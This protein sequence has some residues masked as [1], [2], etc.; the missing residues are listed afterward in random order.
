MI[1]NPYLLLSVINTALRDE[2]SSLRDYCLS[3]GESEEE[4]VNK[5]KE[6]GYEYLEEE[7]VFKNL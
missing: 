5:L 7:N 1:E 4:I 6:I 2:Y 3:T